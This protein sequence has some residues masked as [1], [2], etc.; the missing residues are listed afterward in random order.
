MPLLWLRKAIMIRSISRNKFLKDKNQQ[1]RND[2]QEQRNLCVALVRRAKQQYFPSL[3]LNLIID[4]KYFWKTVKPL[5]SEKISHKDIISLTEDRKTVTEDLQVAQI[6]NNYF[7]N[8]IRIL[9]DWYVLTETDIACSQNTVSTAINKFRNHPSIVS[10]NKNIERTRRPSFAFAFVSSEETIKEVNK[11]SIKKASQ[12][13]DIPVKIIKENKDL[14][15]YVVYVI[16]SITCCQVH[17]TQ[18]I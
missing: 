15:S 2:Y 10:I 13:L 16:I 1:S 18:T 6:F 3:D 14:I 12:A 5:F 4:K 7:I 8:I 17:N 11:L 9:C